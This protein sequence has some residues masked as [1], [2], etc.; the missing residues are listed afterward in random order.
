MLV[1]A[2]ITAA[3]FV[4]GLVRLPGSIKSGIDLEM[5]SHYLEIN[6]PKRA[7]ELLKPLVMR[8]PEAKDARVNLAKAYILSG[9]LKEGVMELNYFEGQQVDEDFGHK[10]DEVAGLLDEKIKALPEEKGATN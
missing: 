9:Q 5:A 8:Y 1:L 2:A 4:I 6:Q 7:A 10:L 3:A